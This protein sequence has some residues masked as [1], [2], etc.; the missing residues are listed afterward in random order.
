M[1][2]PIVSPPDTTGPLGPGSRWRLLGL[3]AGPLALLTLLLIPAPDTMPAAAWRT[4]ALAG[5]MA[6]WWIT[7]A[8]PVAVTA[9]LPVVL[10]PVL[11][12]VD[13]DAAAAP[14]ASPVV[15]LFLGGFLLAQAM[16]QCHLHR[17]IALRVIAA[18]G[19]RPDAIIGGFMAAAALLSM[20]IS[21]TATAVMM[22]PIG[23]SV[24][25]LVVAPSAPAPGDARMRNFP[26]ALMLGIAYAC[27]IG[28]LGTLIGSPPNA[29]LAAFMAERYG[30]EVGFGAWMLI[31][32][33]VV[34]VGL[35]LSWLVLTRWI[36]RTHAEPIPGAAAR[37]QHQI[38]V[39]GPL[40]TAERIVGSVFAATAVAWM[41]RPL[42]E[43][44]ITGLS[45]TGIALG[46][47]VLLFLV[48]VDRTGEHRALEWASAKQLPW[49]V[50]ILFGGGLSL[51]AAIGGSGL[52][53]WLG[54]SAS[55]LQGWPIG[56]TV[57]V[58]TASTI[59]VTELMSNTAAAATFLPVLAALAV[60]LGQPPMVLAVPAALAAS[61][62]FMMP[63][64][65]PPN[66]IVFGSG[67]VSISQMVRAGVVLNL[68]FVV[69]VS[70]LG[71]AFAR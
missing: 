32:M 17:R 23:V 42:L 36:Y 2:S 21:N 29:L 55:G 49:D 4:A 50:L 48:P 41:T 3:V 14:Y 63:V 12:V 16:Q 45:D 61:C 28:G 65:T 51:A 5:F 71:I 19:T 27:S 56:A 58:V 7:E 60:D 26:I 6:V 30:V 34:L 20:W 57:V 62:A 25:T 11:G 15:G 39:L 52:A 13:I 53:E 35:P 70:I 24:I 44:W 46:A 64:A 22:L 40:S 43:R 67:H 18:V 10:L 9:L 37:L 33:P 47:A 1:S 54:A 59:F 8:V 69:L 38:E 68:V 66:A 31:G